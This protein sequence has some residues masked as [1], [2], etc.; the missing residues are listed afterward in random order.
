MK[1]EKI[2]EGSSHLEE[3]ILKVNKLNIRHFSEYMY[4]FPLGV[5]KVNPDKILSRTLNQE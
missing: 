1:L 4:F 5:K 3:L 2:Y